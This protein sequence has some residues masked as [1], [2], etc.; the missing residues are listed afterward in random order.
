MKTKLIAC[1]AVFSM[2]L[3]MSTEANAQAITRTVNGKKYTLLREH[4]RNVK[5]GEKRTCDA[6]M[7]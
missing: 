5:R 6:A 2:S 7:R 3:A 1:I 4:S